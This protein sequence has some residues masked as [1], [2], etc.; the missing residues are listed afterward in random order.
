ML[1]LQDFTIIDGKGCLCAT[2]FTNKFFVFFVID[3]HKKGRALLGDS[4][5]QASRS[6]AGLLEP[7]ESQ[8]ALKTQLDKINREI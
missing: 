4:M 6:F 5:G 7:A 2:S 1:A 8:Q 3:A